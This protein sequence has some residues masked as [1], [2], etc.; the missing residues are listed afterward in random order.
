[1]TGLISTKQSNWKFI[2]FNP[3]T[4]TIIGQGGFGTVYLA[5]RKAYNGQR[6]S[7]PEG[8]IA[9]KVPLKRFPS[10]KERDNFLKEM[11]MMCQV[12]YPACLNLFAW[13]SD[14][15]TT[16]SLAIPLMR[17]SLDKLLEEQRRGLA[18]PE[19]TPTRR[20]CVALAIA[21]GMNY[22]HCKNIIHR[23]L[24]PAN[25]LLDD[26]YLPR[27]ADFG[28]AKSI[29]LQNQLDMTMG[30][31]TSLYMAPELTSRVKP[32]KGEIPYTGKVDVFAY[33]IMLFEIVTV[34]K[35]DAHLGNVNDFALMKKVREGTRP[36][37][38][39][40]VPENLKSLMKR[41]WDVDPDER[42]EFAELLGNRKILLLEGAD[43]NAFEDFAR[44]LL[45]NGKMELKE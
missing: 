30:V 5:Q 21:A 18:P 34:E 44:N 23:D 16:Y 37:I 45:E 12:E 2:V 14:Y 11:E 7:W 29:S 41:C 22:L 8:P 36:K 43:E 35:L 13:E 32:L 38:P 28:L 1:M 27:I 20:S 3:S 17:T 15:S 6:R 31:G 24:K 39:D 9:V 33:G 10:D 40:S 25:V 42:P 26:N 19:W 4:S